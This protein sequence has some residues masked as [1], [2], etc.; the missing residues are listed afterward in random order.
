MVQYDLTYGYVTVIDNELS[1]SM[2]NLHGIVPITCIHGPFH[3]GK[4]EVMNGIPTEVRWQ[5]DVR[6]HNNR[7]LLVLDLQFGE[8]SPISPI[9]AFSNNLPPISK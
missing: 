2:I 4:I 7:G 5:R 1:H 6:R 8:F 3:Q 9:V